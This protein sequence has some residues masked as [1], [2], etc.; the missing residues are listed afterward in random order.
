PRPALLRGPAGQRGG[1]GARHQRRRGAQPDTPV[2]GTA[3][4]S[5]PRTADREGAG[6]NREDLLRD[7]FADMAREEE[8]PPPQRP[9]RRTRHP[10]VAQVWRPLTAA[11][12]VIVLTAATVLILRGTHDKPAETAAAAP[13]RFAPVAELW[14]EALH[15]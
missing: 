4:E 5:R 2:T 13:G 9:L 12:G 6:M 15:A 14:P 7:R 1:Q 11:A 3:Q 8:P 10:L